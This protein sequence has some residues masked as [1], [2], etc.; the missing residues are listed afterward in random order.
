MFVRSVDILISLPS[1]P[2]SQG[3]SMTEV[4]EIRLENTESVPPFMPICS[5]LLYS[6]VQYSEKGDS[7]S[8][9][10]LEQKSVVE[11]H[12]TYMFSFKF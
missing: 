1:L 3:K 2:I 6:S 11:E 12:K 4:S 7:S 8:P 10:K 5:H 9:E